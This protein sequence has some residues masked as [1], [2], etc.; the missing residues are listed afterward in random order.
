[1]ADETTAE[2]VSLALI[3]PKCGQKNPEIVGHL[4]QRFK[5]ACRTT[6]CGYI[7]DFNDSKYGPFLKKLSEL[8]DAFDAT[9]DRP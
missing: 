6:G 1:M 9:A 5:Y 4:R 7:F 8:C 2:N 3:C